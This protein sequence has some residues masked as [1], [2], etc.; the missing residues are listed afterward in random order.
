MADSL[1][2]QTSSSNNAVENNPYSPPE[3]EDVLRDAMEYRDYFE[4]DE[5]FQEALAIWPICPVCGR[6]RI[7][8][9]PIC[10]TIG[11]LFPLADADYWVENDPS[12]SRPQS[13]GNCSALHCHHSNSAPSCSHENDSSNSESD[14]LPKL[15]SMDILGQ[16]MPSAALKNKEEAE[17]KEDDPETREP[18]PN[19]LDGQIMP[20][21]RDWRKNDYSIVE[22]SP[23]HSII[24][25]ENEVYRKEEEIPDRNALESQ[26]GKL[27][28]VNCYVCSESFAPIFPLQCEWCNHVFD[29]NEQIK[30]ST[31]NQIITNLKDNILETES[32]YLNKLQAIQQEDELN[33]KILFVLIAMG[34]LFLAA[35]AYFFFIFN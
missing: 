1:N 26:E 5:E 18:F 30:K 27:K 11:N 12:Q 22:V 17:L 19:T 7:T 34:F 10:K 28:L 14:Y 8:Q 25:V 15:P 23:D 16:Y 31:T 29:E 3:K 6:R 33:P 35:F 20:G 9:C 2:N 24:S 32:G 13:T 4:D 21:V